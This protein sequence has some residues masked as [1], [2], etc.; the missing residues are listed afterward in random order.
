MNPLLTSPPFYLLCPCHCCVWKEPC[1]S[2]VH[3]TSS[4]QIVVSFLSAFAR[5]LHR[6]EHEIRVKGQHLHCSPTHLLPEL[7]PAPA[8]GG[9]SELAFLR[10]MLQLWGKRAKGMEKKG[11][12]RGPEKSK[13]EES[14][15]Q[16][17]C[18]LSL[19]Y[20]ALEGYRNLFGKRLSWRS[21]IPIA[22]GNS[23]A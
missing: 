18:S 6:K 4:L 10:R 21:L 5:P 13:P 14:A 9:S 2:E 8:W 1:K 15:A 12:D 17:T 19:F 22:M 7:P 16:G 20:I 11:D 23:L 3:V